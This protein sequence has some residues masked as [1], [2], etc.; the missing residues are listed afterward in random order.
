MRW[1]IPTII[2]ALPILTF[3]AYACTDS[4]TLVE[5]DQVGGVISFTIVS[6]QDQVAH[7]GEELP[8]PLV[9]QATEIGA[10]GK[11]VI[12][13]GVVVNFVVTS[14]GGSVWAGAAAT[15]KDGI[16]A[17]YLTLGPEYYVTNRVEVRSVDSDGQKHVW[18]TFNAMAK[19]DATPPEVEF[20]LC[21]PHP[22]NP[23]WPADDCSFGGGDK[24]SPGDEYLLFV[25]AIDGLD[26]VTGRAGL[27]PTFS[28]TVSGQP[29][30]GAAIAESDDPPGFQAT[31]PV[32][33]VPPE[34]KGGETIPIVVWVEDDDQ[35]IGTAV[36]ELIVAKK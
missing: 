31:S 25:D 8:E 32:L 2:L 3:L 18:D 34:Y 6:G 4:T 29:V 16:A 17:D 24:F 22:D 33:V 10:D 21:S 7:P 23:Q 30:Y 1:P 5:P 19:E 35:N 15:D 11:E 26:P 20:V 14:G 27:A 12:V 13:P 28:A 9:V 36:G